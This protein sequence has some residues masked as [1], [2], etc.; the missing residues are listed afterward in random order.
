MTKK[1]PTR[2]ALENVH[3]VVLNAC[4]KFSESLGFL[5]FVPS[6]QSLRKAVAR[7]CPASFNSLSYAEVEDAIEAV[8]NAYM[9]A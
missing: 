5:S 3:N 6:S 7:G 2:L 4:V 9:E 8:R 1:I